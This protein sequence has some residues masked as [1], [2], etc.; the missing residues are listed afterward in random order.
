MRPEL[1]LRIHPARLS[2]NIH[3]LDDFMAAKGMTWTFVIKA[4][5]GLPAETFDCL[6]EVPCASVASAQIDV[7]RSYNELHPQAETWWLNYEG[8]A[9]DHDWIDFNLTHAPKSER[10]CHMVLL[11]PLREGCD[12]ASVQDSIK[13][14]A[15]N[16]VGAYLDCAALPDASFLSAWRQF[17]F[18]SSIT[19]SL[20][21]SVS[22][23][24]INRLQE[25]GVNHYRIGELAITGLDLI[26]RQPIPG[27]RQDAVTPIGAQ[28]VL[29]H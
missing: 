1:S 22:F 11:D 19:Q 20:G 7:L 6:R 29:F 12:A 9:C 28:S 17:G 8:V 13:R 5:E 10:D 14:G 3:F 2:E 23:G 16:C 24:E 21:T 27:M 4:F 26:T 25:A 15:C 18:D